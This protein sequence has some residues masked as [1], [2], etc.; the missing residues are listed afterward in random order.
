ME[1]LIL[2]SGSPRRKELLEKVGIHF[3]IIT[4][5]TEEINPETGDPEQI[6]LHNSLLKAKAVSDQ[7]PSRYVLGADTVV[8]LGTKIFG[9]P[10][11]LDQA[12]SFL[13]ELSGKKHAVITGMTLLNANNKLSKQLAVKTTVEFYNLDEET[14]KN[15]LKTINPLDKSG[16]YAIQAAEKKLLLKSLT[17]SMNNV[18][19]LP[20]EELTD[21]LGELEIYK[22]CKKMALS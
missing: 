6:A 9:K 4:A 13:R 5:Q 3:E 12:K 2:A 18:I 10:K 14:I 22:F 8:A 17:G 16:G 1:K 11:D 20:V 15:Y 7:F 19:G 21:W